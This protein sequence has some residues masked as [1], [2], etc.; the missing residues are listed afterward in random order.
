MLGK[1]CLVSDQLAKLAFHFHQ[2]ID[3]FFAC[4]V[5]KV[6]HSSSFYLILAQDD[7]CT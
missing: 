6:P 2:G 3:Q 7:K 4:R 5:L 1:S